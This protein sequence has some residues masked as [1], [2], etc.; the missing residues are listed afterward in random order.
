MCFRDNASPLDL[1]IISQ[2]KQGIALYFF[3]LPLILW[4]GCILLTKVSNPTVG[5]N[6]ADFAKVSSSCCGRNQSF[7]QILERHWTEMYNHV[8]VEKPIALESADNHATESSVEDTMMVT[9]QEARDI[10]TSHSIA[11]YPDALSDPVTHFPNGSA[12]FQY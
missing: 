3:E 11:S 1:G 8:M 12:G 4:F 5:E 9:M 10:C 7:R 6:A 2:S